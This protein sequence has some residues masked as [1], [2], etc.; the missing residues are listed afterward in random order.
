MTK[1][2][3]KK[4]CSAGALAAV[5]PLLAAAQ[6]PPEKFLGFK[7]GADR[8]LAD[9]GQITAYFQK[10]D[11][12]SPR[13]QL[14]TIGESTL[15][16]PMIMAAITSEANMPR[17]D[18]FKNIARRLRDERSLGPEE[19]RRLAGE[20]K[21]ILLITCNI[22]A[23]E[24]AAAQMSMELAHKLVTGDTPF[25][26]ARVLEDVIVLLV[27]TTNPDGEQLVVDWYRKYV[28]TSFEGGS[29]PWLYH[30]YAGHDNNRDWFMFN[31][32]ETR[33]VS[34]VLY[35]DW[36]PQIHIDEH[37]M[38]STGARLFV[39]PFM[40]PPVPVVQPLLWRSIGLCGASMAYDLQ[41][42]GFR[43]VV[44][45]RSYTGWWIGACDDTS[46][47]HNVVGLL[48]EMASV[49]VATPLYIEPNEIPQPYYEKRM[50]FI[51]PWP[52]GWWRL[53][54]LVD[55]E[56]TLSLSL[57]KTAYLHKRDFLFNFYQMYR[58]SAEKTERNQPFAY[59]IPPDQHDYAAS[60]EMIKILM[61][62]GVEVHRAKEQFIAGGKI[63]P[64][65]SFIV[66]LGQPYKPYAWALLERQKYPDLREYPGGPP[67]PPYDNAG[68]TLPLQMGVT[69]DEAAA[70]FQAAL[71]K[72]EAAPAAAPAQPALDAAN[73]VLDCRSNAAYGA[74]FALFKEKAEVRRSKEEV[75]GAG[76]EAAAGSFIVKNSPEVRKA[77]PDILKRWPVNPVPLPDI[78]AVPSAEV[79]A[80][81]IGLYQSWR[82]SMDEGWTRYVF[83]TLGVPY[84]TLHN[85]AFK[86]AKDKK[87]K[88]ADL[89]AKCD[90]IVF[91]D[92]SADIIKTGKPSPES[93]RARF[94]TA[95]Y[96]PEY[97]GG[98]EKEGVE[99]LKAFVE[100]GGV[101]VTLNGA[102]E[103][104]LKDLAA[105]ARN[106]LERVER[107]RFFCPT[108][109]LRIEVDNRAPIGYGMPEKAAAVF[110]DSPA[111]NTRIPPADWDRRVVASY[112]EADVLLS[113]WLLG[114]EVIARKAAVVD[115]RHKKGRIILIG[116]PCQNR[117]Q[118]HGTYKFLLNALLYPQS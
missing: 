106:V 108:S 40:D 70:P 87:D 94:F 33:A 30:P 24:I 80:P 50:E 75:R 98:I 118:S 104:G 13:L 20:G 84:V 116:I 83:D 88:K 61:L 110:A 32:A 22:H 46:W 115:T 103:L 51:D 101:V 77:L 93:E 11:Q 78:S 59:I 92:E 113:G 67:T 43:G 2:A 7:V 96:P 47:L 79:R 26:A 112:P 35:Q 62:G 4:A 72:L 63:Y 27:P 90:I 100:A 28:G 117:A 82:A 10:L 58:N 39:P 36:L 48:S 29:M 114:E 21:V 19:A 66:L 41:K 42:N 64:A 60:L 56:L 76:F 1:S 73:F 14:F 74:V 95:S 81:R 53:R 91:A 23:S 18:A 69:C 12:E 55:Y 25:D 99:A 52:G 45:G 31:L 34:R 37:Q 89:R 17:L 3:F 86:P 111:L 54:D 105:P 97:E 57:V 68:W 6:T 65:G 15:K 109:I 85:D 71:V 16:K 9:Y 44:Q 38:G 107:T 8:Q 5:I 102:C 49:R